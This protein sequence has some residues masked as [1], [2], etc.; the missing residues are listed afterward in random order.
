LLAIYLCAHAVSGDGLKADRFAQ[1]KPLGFG[2]AYN[3]YPQRMLRAALD[4]GREAEEA[5]GRLE[6]L[7]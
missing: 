3:C 2:G 6:G 1:S 4:G 5:T 7:S